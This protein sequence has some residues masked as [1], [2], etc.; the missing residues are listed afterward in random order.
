LG[1]RK[2]C[3]KLVHKFKLLVDTTPIYNISATFIKEK[4]FIYSEPTLSLVL[5]M[6]ELKVEIPE[7]VGKKMKRFPEIN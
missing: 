2:C 4:S 7:E 1:L 6:A 5:E 3:K